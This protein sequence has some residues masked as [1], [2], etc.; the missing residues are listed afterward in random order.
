VSAAALPSEL[1]GL[2]P[3]L[4]PGLLSLLVDRLNVGVVTVAPDFTVLQWNRFMQAHSGRGASEVV[5]QN[6]MAC[7][8]ELPRDWLERKI[9]S[10][11]LLKNFAFTSWRQR[12]YLFLFQ[13]H[14]LVTGGR[15]AM[16]QDCAMVPLIEGGAVKAVSIVLIDATDTYES[17]TRLDAAMN[18]LEALSV[19]DGLTGV[20]NRRKIEE[21]LDGELQRIR[22][23]G[24]ECGVL[25]IDI[26]HFKKVNDGY[27]HVVGDQAIRHV[28]QLA[29]KTLRNTDV[30]GRYGGEE[31]VAA[32]PGVGLAGAAVAAERL[33]VAIASTPVRHPAVTF[34]V[35]VSVGVT[36]MRPES[37]DRISVVESA[38]RALYLSK[39]SGR[40]RVTSCVSDGEAPSLP[41]RP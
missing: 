18:E 27:G 40:N 13:H 28:A 32:L 20:F 25:M 6:L 22:R 29:G 1:S 38:D 30:V 31:F 16:R 36:A 5:G 3:E 4:P 11:F 21:V 8:P 19:R 37:K 26:D 41:P 12:P 9:R 23:Y 35:T 14:R 39:T 33:R 15:G 2:P 7:F 10:V 17:E 24:G 34:S